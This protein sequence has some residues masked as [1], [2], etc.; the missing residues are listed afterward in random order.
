MEENPEQARAGLDE[1]MRRFV[2]MAEQKVQEQERRRGRWKKFV[3]Y[4][5]ALMGALSFLGTACLFIDQFM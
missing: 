5:L 1:A 4:W 2:L 3:L